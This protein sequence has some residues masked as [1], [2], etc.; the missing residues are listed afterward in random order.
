M[1]LSPVRYI[2]FYFRPAGLDGLRYPNGRK[3]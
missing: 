1:F 3:F 2:L